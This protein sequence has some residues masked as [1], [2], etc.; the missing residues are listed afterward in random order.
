M[1]S[2]GLDPISVL[3]NCG[4]FSPNHGTTAFAYRLDGHRFDIGRII[5]VFYERNHEHTKC[6]ENDTLSTGSPLPVEVI[7]EELGKISERLEPGGLLYMTLRTSD[8]G[9][10]EWTSS[11][12]TFPPFPSPVLSLASL[13]RVGSKVHN[14]TIHIV[15]VK[16]AKYAF[17]TYAITEY[18]ESCAHHLV[19]EVRL[20]SPLYC[21]FIIRPVF[22]VHD[23]G[24]RFRGYLTD[25]HPAGSVDQVLERLHKGRHVV[26]DSIDTG[27]SDEGDLATREPSESLALGWNIKKRWSEEI[28]RGV[29]YLHETCGV[30]GDIKLANIVLKED[31]QLVLIDVAPPVGYSAEYVAPEVLQIGL[32]TNQ[33][34]FTEGRDIF[35]LG[36]VL[37]GI[38]E[39]VD[40]HEQVDMLKAPRLPWRKGANCV[41]A[42]FRRLVEQCVQTHSQSRPPAK[43]ILASLCRD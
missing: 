8:N 38:A 19:E 2:D 35:A 21:T 32:E 31:G 3:Y 37:W 29:M 41:P 23:A 17:K 22:A 20:L 16:G 27:A 13:E 10:A 40:H 24:N 1:G 5:V 43:E 26:L 6:V 18:V 28:V 42:W 14:E 33:L 9:Q 34:P 11:P 15:S 12:C 4:A 30:C 25:F 7:R 36:L 39:E